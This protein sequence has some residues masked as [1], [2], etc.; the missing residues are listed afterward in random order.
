[1]NFFRALSEVHS[2]VVVVG[3]GSLHS[4]TG[5]PFFQE[6]DTVVLSVKVKNMLP[7]PAENLSFNVT[8]DPVLVPLAPIPRSTRLDTGAEDSLD[9]YFQVGNVASKRDVNVRLSWSANANESDAHMFKTTVYAG[10]GFWE[11][12]KSPTAIPLWSVHA[13]SSSV[14]WAAGVSGNN[15]PVV[16]KTTNGGD[17]WIPVNGDLSRYPNV[18]L[19]SIFALDS[20]LVWVGDGAGRIFA[21]T[22][23]GVSWTLQGYPAPQSSFIDGLW[24]FDAANGYALGD[25]GSTGKFVILRTTDGGATWDHMTSEP[26]AVAGSY[27]VF[28]EFCCTD[29]QHIWFGTSNA[30]VWRTSDA[31]DTW[32]SVTVGTGEVTSLAM[33][34]DS[35]GVLSSGSPKN[36]E[37]TIFARTSDGGTT[38]Q[39]LSGVKPDKGLA[40]AFPVGSTYV[41]FAGL[42][43]VACSRDN[44]VTWALQP[45][46]PT[47]GLIY[48]VSLFDP[49]HGWMV[50]GQGEILRYHDRSEITTAGPELREMLPLQIMLEQNYPNPFN[51]STM[52]RFD[53]PSRSQVTLAVFNTLGQ[54]VAELINGEVEAGYHEVT[55]NASSLA[56]G[57]YFYRIQAGN[58]NQARKLILLR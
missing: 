8:V 13:V 4:P 34:D 35:V 48:A 12:Q 15:L 38:W 14:V 36:S 51:P 3:P 37:P 29:R 18:G 22:N 56:S 41:W 44:G 54:Q 33:R 24:F 49:T 53:L 57:V 40:A 43:T 50:T 52:I 58:F 55:F 20:L 46:E 9:F 17:N 30:L 31:G 1:M 2:G 28:N 23:G 11:H 7:L 42:Q 5:R 16:L 47:S 45:T 19:Y 26:V 27:G 10:G 6:G 25:P 32:S 39:T 21:T